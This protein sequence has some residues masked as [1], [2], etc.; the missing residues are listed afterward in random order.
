MEFLKLKIQNEVNISLE[1]HNS[2]TAPTEEKVNELD[3][4]IKIFGRET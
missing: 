2:S 1:A 3:K 4:S